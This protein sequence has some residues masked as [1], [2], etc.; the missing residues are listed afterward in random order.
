L[1][2]LQGVIV[3]IL[4][5]IGTG[6]HFQNWTPIALEIKAKIDKW[7]C[8]KLKTFCTEKE[9]LTSMKRQSVEWE[10]NLCK[11]FIGE[12]INIQSI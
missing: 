10:Q 9:I 12:R 6:N 2:L 4:E 3:R 7:T 1:K 11:L 5:G 8:I